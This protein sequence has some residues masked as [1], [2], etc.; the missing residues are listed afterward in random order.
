MPKYRIGIFEEQGG[1]ITIEAK[2][3][4]QAEK[5]ALEL[6]DYNGFSGLQNDKKYNLNLTHRDTMLV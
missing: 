2:T 1:Y 4:T 5:K 3:K 6:L